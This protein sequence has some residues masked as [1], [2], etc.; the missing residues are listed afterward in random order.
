M[1]DSGNVASATGQLASD[2][3]IY[4]LTPDQYE[5]ALDRLAKLQAVARKLGVTPISLTKID[6][7]LV[8]YR[9]LSPTTGE[10]IGPEFLRLEFVCLLAG[11]TP[12]LPNV[13]GNEPWEFVGTIQHEETGNVIK[14][15]PVAQ[16][17]LDTAAYR[18]VHQKCDHCGLYRN[19][20]DTYLLAQG[21][22]ANGNVLQV[23]SSCIKDF[24]GHGDPVTLMNYVQS[25][26]DFIGD[27]DDITDTQRYHDSNPRKDYF[28]TIEFLT[29]TA[30]MVRHYGW[31]SKA[32]AVEADQE[33]TVARVW[34]NIHQHEE[35]AKPYNDYIPPSD[36]DRTTAVNAHTWLQQEFA[37]KPVADRNEFEH[38]LITAAYDNTF[39]IRLGGFVAYVIQAHQ[40]ALADNIQR[41]QTKRLNKHIGNPG[42][43]M[44]LRGLTVARIFDYPNN[45]DGVTYKH[46]FND[47][48]GNTYTWSTGTIKLTQGSTYDVVGTIKEHTEYKGT[49]QTVLTRCRCNVAL[50]NPSSATGVQLNLSNVSRSK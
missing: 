7:I 34:H 45:F 17:R 1:A 21:F 4:K 43:K 40:R 12:K 10:P 41:T 2:E 20:R 22:A 44:T 42:D 19:R 38:N 36:D 33:A 5:A 6:D 50:A 25:M 47:R 8:P 39:E 29:H 14:L 3:R 48:H 24:L 9:K 13:N 27:V 26:L 16:G 15:A 11:T 37:A 23:G 31:I 18:Q 35:R 28:D 32:K 49:N 30:C 46:I